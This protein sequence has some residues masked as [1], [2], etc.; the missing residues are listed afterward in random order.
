M[1]KL[2]DSTVQLTALCPQLVLALINVQEIYLDHGIKNVVVT[3]A[4]DAKHSKTSLHYAG[5]AVDLRV[6]GL[7]N[8]RAVAD[9]I[10]AVMGVDFDCIYEG[11]H[12]HLEYQPKRRDL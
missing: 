9:E 10:S 3:S 4:N 2:K 11:D 12:I 5:H 1:I 7:A 6:H 8:P